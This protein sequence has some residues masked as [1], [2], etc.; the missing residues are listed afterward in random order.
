MADEYSVYGNNGAGW[1]IAIAAADV[2]G[3][4]GDSF[5]NKKVS[6]GGYQGSTHKTN[7]AMSVDNCSPNH[8]RNTEYASATTVKLQGGSA[9]IL[10][11]GNVLQGDCTLRFSYRDTLLATVLE[12]IYLFVYDGADIYTAPSGIRVLAFER[13][14]ATIN[15]DRLSD[16]V[17]D[18]G[19]W[20]GDKGIGNLNNALV[21]DDKASA[22]IHYFYVGISAKPLSKGLKL[23]TL[24]LEFTAS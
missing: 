21:L 16:V 9:V 2:I 20:D 14:D 17:G 6:V 7:A 18:G 8:M 3:F 5:S 15:K 19:A 1:N 23:A 10:N 11:I 13:G 22:A 12:D 24:R 4:F